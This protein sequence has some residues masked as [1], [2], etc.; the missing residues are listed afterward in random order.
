MT[1]YSSRNP[2]PSNRQLLT[3]A[4]IFG[5]LIVAVFFLISGLINAMV[6]WIPVEVE[7]QLGRVIVP[8][9]EKQAQDSLTQTKLNQR[10]DQ[11]EGYLTDSL[12]ENRDYRLLY[13]PEDTINAIAIPGDVIVVY[14]E[15][16]ERLESEN[17]LMMILGHE[18]GHFDHRDHLRKLGKIVLIKAVLSYFLGDISAL[19]S[20]VV[21]GVTVISNAQYSQGQELQADRFGLQ[22]LYQ[23]YGHVAGATD[24]FERIAQE[25]PKTVE[26]LS[27]HPAPKQR[28][29][30]LKQLIEERDYPVK[31]KTPLSIPIQ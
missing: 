19:E 1:Q 2:P 7:Q 20:L 5:G 6:W 15:L 9:Y 11:L 10:L 30:A 8:V 27:T 28:V 23:N 3:L 4:A 13:I 12:H 31:G 16:L 21:D 26:F 22:L 29:K 14:R 24:F 17:E 25:T 18:L